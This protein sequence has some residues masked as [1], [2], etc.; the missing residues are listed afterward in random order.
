MGKNQDLIVPKLSATVLVR[1][2][3][4]HAY[5]G[6][7]RLASESAAH[8][9]HERVKDVLNAEGP[10][11]P[12]FNPEKN[13]TTLLNK[14]HI[15]MVELAAPDLASDSDTG[16]DFGDR[17]GL[18]VSL[19]GGIK[20]RGQVIINMPPDKDRTLD[21]LNRGERFFYLNSRDG[22]RIANLDHVIQVEEFSR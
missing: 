1:L 9:G 13:E 5:K 16:T 2:T 21:F 3:D 22:L 8:H 10:M 19:T 7:F 4:G 12:F 15:L 17:R 18:V 6:E 11:I 20:V 14:S